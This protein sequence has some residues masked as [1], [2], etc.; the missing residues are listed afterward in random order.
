LRYHGTYSAAAAAAAV[1]AVAAAAVAVAV[2][3]MVAVVAAV[4]G[5]AAV[6]GVAQ[7]A[8]FHRPSPDAEAARAGDVA[9]RKLARRFE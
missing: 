2:V 8:M 6:T 5:G 9:R 1:A 7:L 4:G 3:A